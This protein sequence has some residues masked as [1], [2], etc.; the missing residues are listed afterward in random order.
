MSE[1]HPE[2]DSSSGLIARIEAVVGSK[3]LIVE[4]EAMAP[5]LLDRRE[6][7]RGRALAVVKPANTEEAAG[8]VRLCAE[9]RVPM[10]PQGGNTG[11][12]GGG[13][14]DEESALGCTSGMA[15]I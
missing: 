10:V 9:V 6:R 12:V 15:L 7:Y 1:V 3:G 4:A 5:H 11:L 13:I 14:P 8:V 2:A